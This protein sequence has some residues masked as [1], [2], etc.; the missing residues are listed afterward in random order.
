VHEGIM[1]RPPDAVDYDSD[2]VMYLT[3]GRT[4]LQRAATEGV[5]VKGNGPTAVV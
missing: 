5:P 4:Q 3:N 1:R 2:R